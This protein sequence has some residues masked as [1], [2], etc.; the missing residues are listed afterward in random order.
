[1]LG[2]LEP[3]RSCVIL[4]SYKTRYFQFNWKNRSAIR[5]LQAL[6]VQVKASRSAGSADQKA[7]FS[8]NIIDIFH[9]ATDNQSSFW[10]QGTCGD[11][12][13]AAHSC[14]RRGLSMLTVLHVIPTLEGG[15]AERQ[16][17]MLA[18]EQVRRGLDVHVAIRRG[19]VHT[20][21]MRDCGVQLHELGNL[22]SV[23]PRLFLAIRRI[24]KNIEPAIVQTWLPQMDIL[25]GLAALQ[26]HTPWIV[27][28]RTSKEHYAEIPSVARLRL[29]L[30]RFASAIVANSDGGG[31][32]WQAAIGRVIKPVM[33]R[34]ALNF[35]GIQQA[36]PLSTV[37][38]SGPLFLVVGRLVQEKAQEV[39]VQGVG[40]FA[41]GGSINVAIIG[42]GPH[43]A[44]I[45][46]EIEA[47][48][49]SAH[50][51]ILP[52]QPDWWR[53]LKIADGLIS[54]SRYEGN[55]N[56]VL[57]AM[58]GG[59]PVILSD[60]PAHR[61]VADASAAVFVP[62][63][64]VQALSTAIAEFIADKGA[65][66]RRAKCASA[67]VGSMTLTAMADAYDA[68]YKDVLNWKS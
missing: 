12:D 22:R 47:A 65:A 53:W 68:V 42:E 52:Y 49:L 8:P 9:D 36:E 19:G 24:L 50:V 33:I 59:C 48:S 15:G 58:A 26:C 10:F 43:L 5:A 31:H 20:E 55:P 17:S 66:L 1:M 21:A 16:L 13:A 6:F 35:E 38:F 25:G 18:G 51:R 4:A 40:N 23:D 62:V 61:E 44:V 32:Y 28:E 41:G 34:N 30:G 14:S 64:D 27:T 56:V 3:K 2:P 63:D 46:K 37:S 57:E 60:I 29:F 54:M 39:I 11:A 45:Q 67:R 7:E